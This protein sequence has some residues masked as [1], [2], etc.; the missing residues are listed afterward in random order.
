MLAILRSGDT[1][2]HN[3][4]APKLMVLLPFGPRCSWHLHCRQVLQ[5]AALSCTV[6]TWG[7]LDPVSLRSMLGHSAYLYYSRIGLVTAEHGSTGQDSDAVEHSVA[8]VAHSCH[9]T[10][11]PTS[12]CCNGVAGTSTCSDASRYKNE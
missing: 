2:S 5:I 3:S 12:C 6:L 8:Q 11:G 10:A 9:H 4:Q 7:N 1:C